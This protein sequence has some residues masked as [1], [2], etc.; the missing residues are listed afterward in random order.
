MYK[1]FE[2][3]NQ[4]KWDKW[5]QKNNGS[6]LQS[7]LWGQFQKIYG[8]KIFYMGLEEDGQM[9]AG[10]LLIK[11]PLPMGKHYFFTPAGPVVYHHELEKAMREL[12]KKEG[13]L[14]WRL[15]NGKSKLAKKV[16]DI[17]PACTLILSLKGKSEED[18]L[19]EMKPKTR[20]NIKL[21]QKKG[22]VI[23]ITDNIE[24]FYE[25]ARKTASRQKIG[26]HPKGYYAA[27][28]ASLEDKGFLKLYTAEYQGKII[29]ANLV[30]FYNDTVVYL[31]G[32][33][34][35]EY[36]EVMAPHL[37]QW[38]AICDALKKGYANYDFFGITESEDPN[39]PWAGITR[40]KKGF[41]GSIK[42]FTGTYE[43]PIDKTWYNIYRMVKKIRP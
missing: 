26:L 8:R 20:Y 27:M 41:G 31:H 15:E 12:A 43:I 39:H 19:K 9:I 1:I 32:G 34:G 38:Q 30:V 2:I 29:A 28:L 4:E 17:H 35:D 22:V 5:I 3:N 37:L 16:K 13:V 14:F 33:T 24:K 40:F 6:F 11:Y 10:A 18:L 36:R 7:W 25:L 23:K 21:A 42:K